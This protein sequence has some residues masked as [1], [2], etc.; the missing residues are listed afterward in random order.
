MAAKGERSGAEV[1]KES[2]RQLRGT[3]GDALAKDTDHFEKADVA[4]LKFHG[5]YQQDDREA[6]K[7]RKPGEDKSVRSYMFMVRSK[8]PGGKISAKQF[9][10]ELDLGERFG[11]GTLRIT[12]RQGFQLH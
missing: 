6:R 5:T 7:Q 8:I 9:L 2:S 12:T 4:L 10:T 1:I 11:N 3:I